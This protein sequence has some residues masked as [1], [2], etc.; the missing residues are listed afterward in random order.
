MLPYT[1][2]TPVSNRSGKASQ[3]GF[4][5]ESASQRSTMVQTTARVSGSKPRRFR[6]WPNSDS[7]AVLYVMSSLH[8][9]DT[10]VEPAAR[11]EAAKQPRKLLLLLQGSS[12]WVLPLLLLLLLL[13]SA[14]RSCVAVPSEMTHL[15]GTQEH[16]R[17]RSTRSLLATPCK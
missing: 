2:H 8:G 16:G 4:A 5:F 17:H 9:R 10:A 14:G 7:A 15:R 1:P 11:S 3:K 13:N 6:T 12:A